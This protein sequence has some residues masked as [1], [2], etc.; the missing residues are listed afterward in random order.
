VRLGSAPENLAA[1][2]NSSAHR[3]KTIET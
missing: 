3:T 2:V 1:D